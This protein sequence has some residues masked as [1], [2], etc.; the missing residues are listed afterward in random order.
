MNKFIIKP[1]LKNGIIESF[2]F[3][4][5]KRNIDSDLAEKNSKINFNTPCCARCIHFDPNAMTE[6]F[7]SGF[8]KKNARLE[9]GK[10]EHQIVEAHEVC[11]LFSDEFGIIEIEDSEWAQ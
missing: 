5:G 3:Q 11:S 2:I 4:S 1:I 6:N 9:R 7:S 8:C 10:D